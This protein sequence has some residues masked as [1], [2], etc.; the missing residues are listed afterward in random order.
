[1]ITAFVQRQ[2][3]VSLRSAKNKRIAA[4]VRPPS[5]S[6]S[7]S[8]PRSTDQKK[9]EQSGLVRGSG[10]GSGSDIDSGGRRKKKKKKSKKLSMYSTLMQ[11][12]EQR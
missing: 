10:S 7:G 4:T 11:E 12:G 5:G 6:S 3:L 1:M 2:P 8:H 9:H